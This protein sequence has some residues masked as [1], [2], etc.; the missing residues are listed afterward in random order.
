LNRENPIEKVRAS[1][2]GHTFHE[3]W[4][5]RRA[6]QLVFPKDDLFAIAVEGLSTSETA[7]PG[8]EAEDIADLTLYFGPGD[9]FES[10]RA[11]QTLQ[12]KYKADGGTVTSSYF[13]KT[14][15]KFAATLLG[16]EK[17]FSRAEVDTKVS[18][19]FV[20]NADFAEHLWTAIRCLAAS[21]E[22]PAEDSAA[23]TQYDH[24]KHWCCEEK[25]E[26]Y[27][28][29]ARIEFQAATNDLPV[30]N[31]QLRK[32]LSDW[33]P[34]V[35]SQARSR[36]RGLE[37]LIREKAG[38]AGQRNNLVKRE[39]ILDS[40]N[41]EPEDL[42]PANTEFVDIGTII[43]REALNDAR[44]VIE[45]AVSPVFIF[46]DG[47]VGKTVFIQS[48][49]Q[50]MSSDFE[51]VIFDCFGGGNYRAED[52][53][54]HLPKVGLLQIVNELAFRGLC[55]PQLPS[56][57]DKFALIK[58]AK[59]RLK[60]AAVT[61]KTQSLKNGILVIIDAADNAQ[62]EADHRK[63]DA[64][65]R[66]LLASLSREPVDG[67]KLILTARP[68]RMNSVI[69]HSQV[70]RFELSSFSIEEARFFLESRRENLS[71]L[72]LSTAL[73]RSDRNARV[74]DY[75][76]A[77]WDENITRT[78][79]NKAISVEDL[80]RQRCDK[81]SNDLH[82]AGWSEEEAKQFF[83]AISLLPPPI[84]LNEMADALGW[85]H[86]K[87][88]SAIADLAPMLELLKNGAIF[89]DEPTETYIR[90]TYATEQSAQQDIADR[91]FA[92]QISSAY[93]AEALPHFLVV[94]NDSRRAYLLSNSS[95]YPA[96]IQ[97][98]YGRRSLRLLR[99]RAALILAVK[100]NDF[101]R[102]QTLAV[103]MAQ[104][105]A[106]NAKSDEFIRRSPGLS[107][108]LGD[109]DVTRRLFH[110]RTGWRGARD[111]R[112]TVAFAFQQ[113]MDEASIHQ[114]RAIGWIN[115]YPQH[116]PDDG[117]QQ[118]PSTF[119]VA[120]V[121]FLGI[122]R[123]DYAI[124]DKNIASWTMDSALPICHRVLLL[125][126]QYEILQGTQVLSD[127]LNFA[128]SQDCH[129]LALRVSL[130]ASKKR[131]NGY[132]LKQL[133][134][135]SNVNTISN[136]CGEFDNLAIAKSFFRDAALTVLIYGSCKTDSIILQ[137]I[138][139]ERITHY[140][141]QERNR[142]LCGTAPI[143][144]AC[145]DAWSAGQELRF[146]HLLP[147]EVPVTQAV[148]EFTKGSELS[149][150]LSDLRDQSTANPKW[151]EK[152]DNT[153][154]LFTSRECENIVNG[155]ELIIFLVQPLQQSV[156]AHR[157]IE[158]HC[159][160]EFIAQWKSILRFNIHFR[161]ENARDIL[162]KNIG[163]EL[164]LVI[165]RHAKFISGDDCQTLIDLL[166][167]GRFT[168]LDKLDVISLL[169]RHE[170]LHEHTGRFA[171]AISE[172]ILRNEHI[173][174]RANHYSL[175]SE[176]LLPLG[177]KEAQYYF[178][179][180]LSQ[181]DQ[182]GGDD[183]QMIASL[184]GYA[185]EQRGGRLKPELSHRL[186]N[187]CQLVFQDEPSRFNWQLFAK[188]A[189]QS[190]GYQAIFKLVRWSDQDVSNFSYGLPQLVC[191]L[192]KNGC[193][194][195]RRAAFIL[196]L[197]EDQGWYEWKISD[198]LAEI[199]EVAKEKDR[200]AIFQV[201]LNKYKLENPYGGSE[202]QWAELLELVD[203]YP[204]ITD[205]GA[206]RTLEALVN[207]VRSQRADEARYKAF[208][209]GLPF[210]GGFEDE[211]TN[212]NI[213]RIFLQVIDDCDIRS[214]QS[215][216]NAINIL[217]EDPSFTFNARKRVLESLREK[218]HY[219]RRA[220]FLDALI[221]F[222]EYDF[223]DAIQMIIETIE[224]WKSS[225]AHLW[226]DRGKFI[227]R[228]FESR[229]SDFFCSQFV[230]IHQE[231]QRIIDFCDDAGFVL[232]LIF[233]TITKEKVDL[234]GD[235]W[236]QLATS[237]CSCA[238]GETSLAALEDLLSGSA[239]KVADEIGE[240]NFK[241]AYSPIES[242]SSML[243]GITWH[244]LG[245][246]KS[247]LRWKAARAIKGLSDLGL[248][249]DI[250]A[251][252]A[253]FDEK[254]VSSLV[255]ENMGS[256][257]LNSRQWL[258]MGLSRACFYSASKLSYL[259]VRLEQLA[260]REDIH[261]VNKIHIWRCL[262]NI[263]NSPS[264]ITE[265]EGKIF[266]P[267]KGYVDGKGWANYGTS[268]TGFQLDYDFRKHKVPSLAGLFGITECEAVD[269]IA[270]E[271][272]REWPQAKGMDDFQGQRHSYHYDS[273]GFDSYGDSVQRHALLNVATT[274]V[275]TLPV[276]GDQYESTT[277][278]QPWADW[279]TQHDISFQ[280]GTWLADRK[281]DIPAF[282]KKS[283]IVRAK[284]LERFDDDA[285]LLGKL[286]LLGEAEEEF[287]PLFG[288]WESTEGAQVYITS[289]LAL[290]KGIVGRCKAFSKEPEHN[291]WLPH[292]DPDGESDQYLMASDFE[293][294]L[295]RPELQ[296]L[297]IDNDDEYASYCAAKR[298][299]LGKSIID[300]LGLKPSDK[301][302]QWSTSEGALAL[303]SHV[304]G[305]WRPVENS[306]RGGW[307]QDV[308][309]ILT[310]RSIWLDTALVTLDRVLISYVS[311]YK[312]K[313]K[314][315]YE[316]A[317]ELNEV[318]ICLRLQDGTFRYWKAKAPSRGI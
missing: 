267:A 232:T 288:C 235:Q 236:L 223:V 226:V 297:G 179:E 22:P 63:E 18:F 97:S 229:G 193:L 37:E 161:A 278:A 69:G 142:Q 128:S 33:T 209:N 183:Y 283:L 256:S 210:K 134:C 305:Q 299:R 211:L 74:L 295:S 250:E 182:M 56:D 169:A 187:L 145:I 35:D 67:V 302:E 28:L 309:E 110:D 190:I 89:R 21:C 268:Q 170:N 48:L 87:V 13:K 272:Q 49:A 312:S 152:N 300:R 117:T 141:Y 15:K 195:P 269:A 248:H 120:S 86:S 71:A 162:G 70:E 36:L 219:S 284:G 230:N 176:A 114:N 60:Q 304:W 53:A 59:T 222:F 1:R 29:F 171:Q 157:E 205:Q 77:S 51:T 271:I 66:L 261:V 25:I 215:I 72:E 180:G 109:Q 264:S 154:K 131:F 102:V 158:A 198:G 135:A 85:P 79:S 200:P 298:A 262:K 111:S 93:A 68:P 257:F 8:E 140:S 61:V 94:I 41:C 155:V 270:S 281:D 115:W 231:L 240:G 194:E 160:H 91:L 100:V 201:L 185:S 9:S 50:E 55:D 136:G 313:S 280:D 241:I 227:Q 178:R 27:R 216:E 10:C 19:S 275:K 92:Q 123:G 4:A 54:R 276:I 40:L 75:L 251:L 90:E 314:R 133:S 203:K 279:L 221:E 125:L 64:F 156:L 247:F 252:L 260:A 228:I 57:G 296:H 177:I 99:L 3:R 16:Y 259:Q 150:F 147:Q 273:T 105:A 95:D 186:M 290:S 318:F 23:K 52:Q 38:L 46:A 285:T 317:P 301:F 119:D 168:I 146:H 218:C 293:P 225:S 308:G 294:L 266:T 255:S 291:I 107:V 30:L 246:E 189:A 6:L 191:S 116:E 149:N 217:R 208:S 265:L 76:V 303:R 126:E 192:A 17:D 245:N 130:L 104:V 181:L 292:F 47:G 159:V 258:L 153:K 243:V 165:L 108:R 96:S 254:E 244:L 113:E 143:M 20:T 144:A 316:D 138:E 62:V 242:E 197:C 80:I 83:V 121:L 44:K 137:R 163:L 43:K 122:L 306:Y 148:R 287:F 124:A 81:I 42:F 132:E 106:A 65:P 82:R 139:A 32:I 311:V 12:F 207:I 204:S 58:A 112:L 78:A 224:L 173:G 206:T 151:G 282:A 238:L 196:L 103:D 289:A 101:D 214:P 98:E 277:D 233:N 174:Q 310:A 7:S 167:N 212:T 5:A 249:D 31:R 127:L 166:H 73:A 253:R 45:Q 24:L 184:L 237:L 188:A 315:S 239:A 234:T 172:E 26:P 88:K 220:E 14:L 213:E 307:S 34:G 11:L 175:L 199:L 2:A 129:S 286:G 274:L 84:P 39:D 164:A 202:N 118:R 263:S